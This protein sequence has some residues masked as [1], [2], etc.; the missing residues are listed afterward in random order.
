MPLLR[1]YKVSMLLVDIL[2]LEVPL[3]NAWTIHGGWMSPKCQMQGLWSMC[4]RPER[5]RAGGCKA[6]LISTTSAKPN[7]EYVHMEKQSLSRDLV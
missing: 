1:T 4:M 2:I 6:A 3:K 5:H 7:R